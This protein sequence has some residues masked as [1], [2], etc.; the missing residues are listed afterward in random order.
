MLVTFDS[1]LEL[2]NKYGS[3]NIPVYVEAKVSVE[4]DGYA[5][6]DSPTLY[7]V[8]ITSVIMEDEEVVNKLDPATIAMLEQEVFDKDLIQ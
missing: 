7:E 3:W 5:T 8:K 1:E 6:G 2:D 4:K